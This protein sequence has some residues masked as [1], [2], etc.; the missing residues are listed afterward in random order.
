MNTI[1]PYNNKNVLVSKNDIQNILKK[2]DIFQNITNLSIYQEAFIHQSYTI[3]YIKNVMER[4]NVNLVSNIDGFAQL[5]PKSYETLEY[6]GDAVIELIISNYLYRRFPNESEGFLSRLRVSLVNRMALSHLS[7]ILGLNKYLVISKTLE[8]KEDGRLKVSH[9]ED[10]FEAF[11]GAI[12]KDFNVVNSGFGFQ[13]AETFL[14]N[15]IE[16][17]KS[18]IDITALIMDDGN[19]KTKIVKYYRQVYKTNISFKII[20]TDGSSGLKNFLVYVYRDDIRKKLGEGNGID[21]K[22]AIQNASKNA[23]NNQGLM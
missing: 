22:D 1:N 13:I 4:D 11:I 7:K 10:I 3:P 15:L 21:K 12:F 16:D 18:E 2:Y 14:I 5:Q 20:D 19:Y 23:L 9:L 6:L 8:E 17:E